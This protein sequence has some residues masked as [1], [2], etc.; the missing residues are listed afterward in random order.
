MSVSAIRAFNIERFAAPDAYCFLWTTH[1][2]LPE[3]LQVLR[4]WGFNYHATLTWIKDNGF[5][6]FGPFRFTSEFVLFGYRDGKKF[7][8]FPWGKM[9]TVFHGSS[10]RHSEKPS[11]FYQLI[12]G[13]TPEP[14][15]DI[16]ARRVHEGFDA[17]GNEVESENGAA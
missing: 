9:S 8:E 13:Y 5:C 4:V 10:T 7:R 15:I 2:F 3:A 17:W 1:R 12:R 14:R 6:P 11:E 16:F